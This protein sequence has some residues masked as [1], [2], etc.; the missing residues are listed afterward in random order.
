MGPTGVIHLVSAIISLVI[1][2]IIFF[3]TK[4][5]RLHIMLGRTYVAA[6]L[7]LNISAL[8]IYKLFGGFG[9]F[10]I[11]I[12]VSLIPLTYGTAAVFFKRPQAQW[13]SNHYRAMCWSYIGLVAAGVAESF[14]R[15]PLLRN[16]S[17]FGEWTDF[18]VFVGM[19]ALVV[20]V[21][22]GFLVVKN[23]KKVLANLTRPEE[24]T[25]HNQSLNPTGNRP[26]S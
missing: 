16:I 20:C 7:A 11:L 1:G 6:M 18:G 2:P 8:F 26:A 19:L 5:T 13:L 10:H 4:G 23:E 15:I 24:R 14:V 22:G 17:V 9:V 3:T 21:S 25:R 12:P